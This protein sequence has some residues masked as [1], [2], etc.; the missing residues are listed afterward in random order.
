[1]HT[2]LS[3]AVNSWIVHVVESCPWYREVESEA[4]EIVNRSVCNS[5]ISKRTEKYTV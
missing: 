4:Y 1:M 5:P 3:S 2:I